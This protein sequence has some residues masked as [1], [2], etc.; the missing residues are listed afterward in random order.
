MKTTGDAKSRPAPRKKPVPCF[1]CDEP[2]E[3]EGVSLVVEEGEGVSLVVG[4][5]PYSNTSFPAKIGQLMGDGFMVVVTKEDGLCRRCSALLNHLDKLEF[6][7]AIVKKALTGYLKMKYQLLDEGEEEVTPPSDNTLHSLQLLDQ[8][9]KFSKVTHIPASPPENLVD[10]T[11]S[12]SQSDIKIERVM[13]MVTETTNTNS[14]DKV[15]KSTL[16]ASNRQ[17]TAMTLDVD[18]S[19]P[20]ATM[21][22]C[23]SCRYK[24]LHM[25]SFVQHLKTH[26]K[27]TYYKCS[28]CS[29]QFEKRS[30]AQQH[31]TTVHHCSDVEFDDDASTPVKKV[32]EAPPT[33]KRKA[34]ECDI[35]SYRDTDKDQ[36]DKH[37]LSHTQPTFYE[38]SICSKRFKSKQY[39]QKHMKNH[40]IYKCGICG[41]TFRVKL[42]L[43]KHFKVHKS[44]E[45]AEDPPMEETTSSS[46][47]EEKEN[48]EQ[49]EAST[50][51]RL[52]LH[53][54]Y[55]RV[56]Q[57]LEMMHSGASVL[58]DQE[59]KQTGGDTM[60]Q[61]GVEHSVMD[62]QD[63]VDKV[64][65]SISEHL[66][67]EKEEENLDA[68]ESL[69]E[70]E[71]KTV[72]DSLESAE[73]RVEDEKEEDSSDDQTVTEKR[74]VSLE[75]VKNIADSFDSLDDVAESSEL[76]HQVDQDV[77]NDKLE[78]G[79]VKLEEPKIEL[80][81][82]VNKEADKI[83]SEALGVDLNEYISNDMNMDISASSDKPENSL[84]SLV[85]ENSGSLPEMDDNTREEAIE[86]DHLTDV[87]EPITGMTQSP[88]INASKE[89]KSKLVDNMFDEL[90]WH[91]PNES[92]LPFQ[93][94]A[95]GPAPD[96]EVEIRGTGLPSLSTAAEQHTPNLATAKKRVYLCSVCGLRSRSK[97]QI[98]RHL[99]SHVA[100]R[101]KSFVCR[102]CSKIFTTQGNLTR[103]LVKHSPENKSVPCD[104][105]DGLFHDRLHL[106]EHTGTTHS[107]RHKCSFCNTLLTSRKA[108]W[109]HEKTHPERLVQKCDDCGEV[110][111]TEV[112]LKIHKETVHAD[113]TFELTEGKIYK[114]HL[115][116]KVVSTYF[117]LRRHLQSHEG[118]VGQTNCNIRL[119]D[120]NNYNCSFCLLV[121]PSKQLCK[122]HEA[123]HP[124][125]LFHGCV[126]CGKRFATNERL[127]RHKQVMHRDPHC[128]YCGRYYGDLKKLFA[129][130]RR[131]ERYKKMSLDCTQCDKTFKTP[132]GLKFHMA[133][134]T[135]EYAFYCEI[136]GQGRHSEV[137]L[138]EHVATHTKEIRYIC[139]YCGKKFSSNSTYR[140]HR[141]WHK[142]PFPYKC[143]TC[144][145]CFKHTSVLAVHKRRVHTGERPHKCPYCPLSFTVSS[146]LRKH[147]ILHTQQFPHNCTACGKGYT[148]RTK[149]ARH[150]AK[151]HSDNE[152]L[153]NLG[154][155]YE[156]KMAL[157]PSEVS[158][159]VERLE[160]SVMELTQLLPR[161]IATRRL[162]G[163]MELTQLLRRV[164]ATRRLWGV[165][166]LTQLLR[167]VI[168]VT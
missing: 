101:K 93:V 38:C 159:S 49:E 121:F 143:T 68:G 106:K 41:L 138:A 10:L 28:E 16:G 47:V 104:L 92:S 130:E 167:R 149:L 100:L 24:T 166:E 132:T 105:C 147:V 79:T 135:G 113:A 86:K 59:L 50:P 165:M 83:V 36:F 73:E 107:G 139:D 39:L 23:T 2:V 158:P 146:T 81:V 160:C 162:W 35:C 148:T 152:M 56:E 6:D 62:S 77:L 145:K 40:K 141:L 55:D 102:V 9:N 118:D 51:K 7:L 34:F 120:P 37:L 71:P 123:T 32:P 164:I 151:A 17:N 163:V 96:F 116:G 124:E 5:T 156:Y 76:I 26:P 115:C 1:I 87:N 18:V 21:Y 134:H 91:C 29:Q 67:G 142:N 112:K 31:I 61:S 88:V 43:L 48:M 58:E 45:P 98:R 144:G 110:F 125:K 15:A 57:M 89:M 161:V 108:R 80:D 126:D 20:D 153:N 63:D 97:N 103:H 46:L 74:F 84:P 14:R 66:N 12:S 99:R 128:K 119:T 25:L 75:E 72:D 140:I 54:D 60:E 154:H 117:N 137:V 82:D 136:C 109:F 129:H 78:N 13:S 155:H 70:H 8:L 157:R 3:G 33:Q 53:E 11:G 44:D 64:V 94:D 133:V 69:G 52:K 4:N 19:D 150:L 114:C 42:D 90:F 127:E 22:R 85:S 30:D 168:G 27:K 111:E 131:H 65:E 95:T 122:I